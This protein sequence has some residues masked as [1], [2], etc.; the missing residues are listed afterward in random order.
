MLK[1]AESMR[2]LSEESHGHGW[3][4][5][6]CHFAHFEDDTPSSTEKLIFLDW[7][8]T[9]MPTTDLVKNWNLPCDPQGW[10]AILSNLDTEQKR[11]LEEWKSSLAGFMQVANDI[12]EVVIITNA[13]SPWVHGCIK[14]LCPEL[15]PLFDRI[16]IV[17]ARE[18]LH[19]LQSSRQL[20]DDGRP[21]LNNEVRDEDMRSKFTEAKYHAMRLEVEFFCARC[22]NQQKDIISVGDARFEYDAA[23]E[24]SFFDDITVK[25]LLLPSMCTAAQLARV[26][27]SLAQGLGSVA[28]YREDLA[29]SFQD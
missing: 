6:D 9:L 21:V 16:R 22:A 3:F 1:F 10:P 23:I 25:A 4:S 18:T 26:L 19:Q 20:V 17:Y 11:L 12:G 28:K 8:D 14:A 15:G 7:D 29:L 27:C 5:T 13:R 24:L 2:W